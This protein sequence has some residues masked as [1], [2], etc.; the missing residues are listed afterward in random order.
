MIEITW[1]STKKHTPVIENAYHAIHFVDSCMNP[2]R[3]DSELA[4]INAHAGMGFF[5]VSPPTCRVI[6]E[7]L[8]IGKE[9]GG[10]FDISLFP[11]IHLWGFDT[12]TPHLPQESSIQATLKK[13]G[14][15]KVVCD[16]YHHRVMLKKTGMGLD[17]GGIAKGYAVD[18]AVSLLRAGGLKSFIVNA[19][20]DLYCAGR[21][22]SRPWL[23]GIQDPDHPRAVIAILSLS[24]RAVATS[25]DYENYFV[26]GGVRYHHIL[27]PATGYP[28]RGLRSVTVLS[29]TTMDADALATALFVMG[30]QRAIHWLV[31]HP[32]YAGVFVDTG[33]NI[34]ASLSLKNLTKWAKRIKSHVTYF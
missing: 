31:A 26:K 27:D 19:G 25:G 10:A 14:Y 34:F 28:A 18:R 21:H 9:T 20:G 22:L 30:K 11:L 8:R 5:N 32:N 16:P 23:I 12:K 33:L 4:R 3:Q 24:N 6:E 17:L 13:T 7:G 2:D 15:D 1:I 29:K